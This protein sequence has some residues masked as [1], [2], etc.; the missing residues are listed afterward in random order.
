MKE[1]DWYIARSLEDGF[2]ACLDTGR[3]SNSCFSMD[4]I[5]E[6]LDRHF[7][8]WGVKPYQICGVTYNK[9]Y[10]ENGRFVRSEE[11]CEAIE[12]YP[13]EG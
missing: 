10:D 9:T 2:V 7:Q 6:A 5:H 13:K 3:V 4:E 8:K 11:I 1:Y 12:I